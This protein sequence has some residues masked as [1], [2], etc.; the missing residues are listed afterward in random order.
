MDGKQGLFVRHI[1]VITFNEYVEQLANKISE[2]G[3]KFN[4]IIYI[5]R[6]GMIPAR[7]LSDLLGLSE[8][9]PVIAKSYKGINDAEKVK[10]ESVPE[11]PPG[12]FLLVDDVVDTGNTIEAVKQV[13]L[14]K[15][16]GKDIELAV[17]AVFYKDKG[18]PKPDFYAEEVDKDTWIDFYYEKNE[19]KRLLEKQIKRKQIEV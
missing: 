11:L 4:G 16:K 8:M 6:G 18:G 17:A 3:I 1:N 10:I 13:L 14:K 7:L 19:T 2:T 15:N 12:R 9:Y 5:Q